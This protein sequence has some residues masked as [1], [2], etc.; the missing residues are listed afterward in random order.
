MPVSGVVELNLA[1]GAK[2]ERYGVRLGETARIEFDK[3]QNSL[4]VIGSDGLIA[5]R[6]LVAHYDHEALH[7]V[8]VEYGP[9]FMLYL[10]DLLQLE[11]AHSI[12]SGGITYYGD[13]KLRIGTATI[14][15][16][17][18]DLLYPVPCAM[19]GG[20]C[21]RFDIA[22]DGDYQIMAMECSGEDRSI[23]V[24]GVQ[25]PPEQ[26]DNTNKL[27][28][29]RCTLSAGVHALDSGN[30]GAKTL[31][32][33]PWFANAGECIQVGSIGPFDK[34]HGLRE[35]SDV[36]LHAE[37]RIADRGE[38]WQAGV[39]FRG[40]QFADGGEGNDKELGTN[41]FIG[42]RVCVSDGKIQLWK[43][44]YDETLL[45]ET[46]MKSADSYAFEILAEGNLLSV[47]SEGKQI[48]SYRDAM[49]ILCGRVGFHT[50]NCIL[51]EGTIR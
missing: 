12:K 36:R 28:I 17:K 14:H 27:A 9:A 46:D 7:C 11:A 21:I 34:I 24:D 1:A 32:T 25:T 16:D 22:Q 35:L 13:D 31:A 39:L 47:L 44:R 30:T 41:F 43:H 6:K 37:F 50:K 5:T 45:M 23:Y 20:S 26:R 29:Y 48:L 3:N 42:Y 38:N 18:T 33:V 4:S 10:D 49:P 40:S 19:P 2:T 51:A 15:A 8:R